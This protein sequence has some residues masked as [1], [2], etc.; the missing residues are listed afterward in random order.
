MKIIY[1]NCGVK[2][3]LK[4][5]HRSYTQLMQLRKESLK[6]NLG[7]YWIQTFDFCETG[8]A[9]DSPSALSVGWGFR[10]HLVGIY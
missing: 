2:K 4:E 5:D 7:L 6:K 9:T 1:V 10:G 8:A 3:Y